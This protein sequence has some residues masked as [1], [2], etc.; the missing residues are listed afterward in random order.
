MKQPL[1]KVKATLEWDF[2]E[3][4]GEQ[5][6]V[7]VNVGPVDDILVLTRPDK[8]DNFLQ[9]A[10]QEI[11]HTIHH[12]TRGGISSIELSSSK[13]NFWSIQPLPEER[14][15][16]AE[17]RTPV[18]GE[19][20]YHNAYLYESN[21]ELLGSFPM[22]DAIS[23]VQS[24]RGGEI[25]V[26]YFDE[27]VF[28]DGIGRS[29]LN[30]FNIAGDLR[31]DFTEIAKTST[32]GYMADCYA[33]NAAS[34]EETWVCYYTEFPVVCLKERKLDRHWPAIKEMVGS[35]A[36]AVLKDCMLFTGGYDFRGHLFWH[37]LERDKTIKVIALQPNGDPLE[38]SEKTSRVVGRGAKLYIE[39][40][41]QIWSLSLHVIRP[42]ES[43]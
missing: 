23:T 5:F 20:T 30:A 34:N 15:L 42:P 18:G 27:G 14:Y 39:Q 16:A 28:G 1:I 19:N 40:D 2:R 29:G 3:L 31:F 7:S 35:G 4:V 11:K 17:S 22:G 21:G 41:S 37:D 43:T 26:S 24:S 33:L 25:W 32:L 38:W 8:P 10:I 13:A 9:P 36:F 6:V 12:Q